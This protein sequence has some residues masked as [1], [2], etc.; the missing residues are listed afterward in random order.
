MFREIDTESVIEELQTKI[1]ELTDELSDFKKQFNLSV[2]V[3]KVEL[4]G[5]V[6]SPY[7]LHLRFDDQT[8]IATK[9]PEVVFDSFGRPS[10]GSKL[11]LTLRKRD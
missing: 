8:T 6:K 2:L 1:K 4:G 7:V 5:D 3:T 10:A 9:M 11:M